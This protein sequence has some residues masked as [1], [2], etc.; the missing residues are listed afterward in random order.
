M[1]TTYFY[2]NWHKN[3]CLGRAG[4]PAHGT[5]G[6]PSRPHPL[7]GGASRKPL[8]SGGATRLPQKGPPSSQ[9][10]RGER[11]ALPT[12]EGSAESGPST[13]SAG[14]GAEPGVTSPSPVPGIRQSCA[15]HEV[16]QLNRLIISHIGSTGTELGTAVLAASTGSRRNRASGPRPP[17]HSIWS[18]MRT[19]RESR[20]TSATVC[21][22]N[23]PLAGTVVASGQARPA[24]TAGAGRGSPDSG[25]RARPE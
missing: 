21:A 3:V 16:T 23:V 24:Q 2:G 13:G 4:R 18:R 9:A 5:P 7:G 10:R 19:A 25:V 8:P 12:G 6:S 15:S 22:M 17:G 14:L 1:Q 20:R 11:D